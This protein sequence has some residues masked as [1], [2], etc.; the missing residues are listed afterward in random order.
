V[1][2]HDESPNRFFIGRILYRFD[3]IFHYFFFHVHFSPPFSFLGSVF[4]FG[5]HFRFSFDVFV[6]FHFLIFT[7]VFRLTILLFLIF[8]FLKNVKKMTVLLII[9]VTLRWPMS[10]NLPPYLNFL[11]I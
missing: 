7:S 8:L 6:I 2:S 3:E 4:I 10:S 11:A 9:S 1:S 5:F